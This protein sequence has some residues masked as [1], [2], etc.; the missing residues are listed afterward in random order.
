MNSNINKDIKE[1]ILKFNQILDAFLVQLSPIVGSSYHIKFQQII[2]YNSLLPIEQ[3]LIYAL[4]IKEQII[5]R[6]EKY[7][8]E[9]NNHKDKL[10]NNNEALNEILRLNGIWEKLDNKS[11]NN[12]WDTFTV[13][14]YLGEQFIIQRFIKH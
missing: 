4:P 2:K 11:K 5:N 10:D 1:T 7:F 6:D 3:F 9:T 12:V 13:M 8:I 14:L